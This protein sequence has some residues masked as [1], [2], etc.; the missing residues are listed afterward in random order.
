MKTQTLIQLVTLFICFF[1]GI[2]TL[3]QNTLPKDSSDNYQN[4]I[5]QKELEYDAW[6]EQKDQ[7]YETWKKQKEAE[8]QQFVK[9][10]TNW[11]KIVLGKEIKPAVI[12]STKNAESANKQMKP[13]YVAEEASLKTE[14][15]KL[16]SDIEKLEK[17]SAVERLQ[18]PSF[19]TELS[20]EAV[21]EIEPPKQ[22]ALISPKTKQAIKNEPVNTKK[23]EQGLKE[24]LYLQ[25]INA[26]PNM[27]PI[28][29]KYR[30]SSSFGYRTH[31]I[32]RRLIHHDGIDM[33]CP[34]GTP[35]L[36]PANG[37]IEQAGWVKG[38]GNFIKI[39]HGSGYVT[40]YGHL[41]NIN[42]Q[43]GDRIQKK[44]VIGKV[45]STGNSTG[46]HLHYEVIKNGK[47]LNP[48]RHLG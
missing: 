6:K 18:K 21:V 48:V 12:V 37:I 46:Y 35:V 27:S 41:S 3:A 9:D 24:D 23:S 22:M 38:Y 33:A 15:D 43:K 47:K 11:N 14:F 20:N 7:E 5:K 28:Q 42:V 10:H 45:G 34:K 30:I 40:V 36:A 4:W 16:K 1:P 17:D 39:R 19:A 25:E 29:R 26:I 8:Y 44:F 32:F 31:P 2:E 13:D